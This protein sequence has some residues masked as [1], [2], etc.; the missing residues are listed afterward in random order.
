M[1]LP[2]PV[3]LALAAGAL[4]LLAGCSSRRSEPS[5]MHLHAHGTTHHDTVSPSP[6][7]W[8]QGGGY[9]HG[10]W[11]SGRGYRRFHPSR[12]RVPGGRRHAYHRVH[13]DP[14]I[15]HRP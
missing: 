10:Y 7:T 14:T 11:A 3:L 6:F 15:V 1:R 13:G 12:Y 4:G 2:K 9:G 5:H 8:G